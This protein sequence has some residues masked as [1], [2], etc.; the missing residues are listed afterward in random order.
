MGK[1]TQSVFKYSYYLTSWKISGKTDMS[2][3]RKMLN[4]QFDRWMDRQ[5]TVIL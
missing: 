3:L 1:R 5:R 4:R 2:F